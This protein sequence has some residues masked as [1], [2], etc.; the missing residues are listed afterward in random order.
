MGAD[1]PLGQEID[2]APEGFGQLS[3]EPD[4]SKKTRRTGELDDEVDIA[5]GTGV[6]A[7]ER[8]E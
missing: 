6:T 1:G 2:L 3:L 7:D 4:Q 8:A 5:V